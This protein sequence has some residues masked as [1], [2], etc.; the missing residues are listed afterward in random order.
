VPVH[1]SWKLRERIAEEEGM[2]LMLM[3]RRQRLMEENEALEARSVD[4]VLPSVPAEECGNEPERET[5]QGEE[6]LIDM[7]AHAP[8]DTQVQ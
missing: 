6:D 4:R 5:Q 2:L 1:R 3:E 8:D 7:A